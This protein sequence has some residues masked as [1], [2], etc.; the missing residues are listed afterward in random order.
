MSDKIQAEQAQWAEVNFG[1]QFRPLAEE[2]LRSALVTGKDGET[3][4][5]QVRAVE[6]VLQ[7]RLGHW[8][9]ILGMVEE[10]GELAHAVLKSFQGIRGNRSEHEAAQR[11]AYGDI[12]V[13]MLD[14]ANRKGW[15]DSAVLAEVWSEV[16]R[17]NWVENP[18][19]GG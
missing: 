13:Y 9:P 12:R 4:P 10:L 17:R 2:I 7:Q 19:D 16:R 18:S 3:D 1:R 8:V 6:L 11:D 15:L 5:Q 14:F